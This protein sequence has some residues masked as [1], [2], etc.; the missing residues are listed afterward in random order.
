MLFARVKA[1]HAR[2]SFGNVMWVGADKIN[3]PNGH[4]C[5]TLFVELVNKRAL[6]GVRGLGASVLAAFAQL[7]LRHHGHP[8]AFPH[9]GS[10]KAPPRVV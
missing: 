7:L 1:A 8:K 4:N 2:L 9:V 10:T 3:R 5:L 6:F